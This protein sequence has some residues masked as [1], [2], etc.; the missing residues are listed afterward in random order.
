MKNKQ[1]EKNLSGSDI[2]LNLKEIFIDNLDSFNSSS[3]S[4]NVRFC[5]DCSTK[6]GYCEDPNFSGTIKILDI[7]KDK[8]RDTYS[9]KIKFD[10]EQESKEVKNEK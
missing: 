8:L 6:H 9:L 1:K 7:K 4:G 2:I 5:I 3:C 10:K